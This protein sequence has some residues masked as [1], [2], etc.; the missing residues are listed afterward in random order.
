MRVLRRPLVWVAVL[1]AFAVGAGVAYATQIATADATSVINACFKQNGT[2]RLVAAATDCDKNDTHI[3]W[4]VQGPKGDVGPAGPQGP[5]GPAGP[6]GADGEDGT[7][8]A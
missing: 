1:C 7:D 3:S 4:N 6:A 2:I 5:A 8:G